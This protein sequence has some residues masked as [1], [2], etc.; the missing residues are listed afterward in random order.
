MVS[1]IGNKTLK[2]L[3]FLV[4]FLIF[5]IGGIVFGLSLWV[6]VDKNFVENIRK[7]ASGTGAKIPSELVDTLAQ[8]QNA[9]W[10]FVAIGGLLMVVGFLG[11]CGAGFESVLMLT[12]FFIVVLILVVVQMFALFYMYT[13]RDQFDDALYKALSESSKNIES[14]KQLS[15]VQD[16]FKCCGATKETKSLYIDDLLCKGDQQEYD[17]CY[18]VI[19]SSIQKDADKILIVGVILLFVEA[20]ALLFSCI[21]CRAFREHIPYHTYY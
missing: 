7:I 18:D 10:I 5:I 4:N 21:L 13:G 9:L 6:T 17:A 19:K 11:C 20:F 2:L 14:R 12:L 8:Y 16:F 3:M 15:P 1:G